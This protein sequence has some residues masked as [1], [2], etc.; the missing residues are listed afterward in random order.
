MTLISESPKNQSYSRQDWQKGYESQPNEDDYVIE[1]IE[2]KIPEELNGTLFR[3]GPGLLDI[4]GQKYHH[5]F[6]GDGMISAIT[7]KN[8]KAHFRNRFVETEGYLAEKNAG[9]I[10][11]RG[12]FGTQKPGGLLANIFD[13]KM[14][15]IANTNVIYLGEKLLALWEA[16]QPYHLNPHTLNTIGLDNLEGI[17]KPGEAFSAHPRVEKGKNGGR[18]RVIN[19]SVKPGISS[20]IT[21]YELESNGKLLTKYSHKIPGFSFLHDMAITPNYC[22]FFQNP[23]SFNPLPYLFG[24][25]GAAECINFNP[26][27][28]TQIILIP[29]DGSNDVKIIDTEP[30][31][32]FHHANAWEEDDRVY[33]DSIC[34]KQFN[35]IEGNKDF[36]EVNFDVMPEGQ[37]WRFQINLSNQEV[38]HQ[39]IAQRSCEFPTLNPNNVGQNYR[40]LYIGAAHNPTGNAPLQGILKIDFLTGNRQLWSAAPRGFSGEPTFVPRPNSSAEDDGWLLIVIYNAEYHRSELVI[41][42]A[43][44]FTKKPVAKL[45]LKNHIPYGLHGCFIP[46]FFSTIP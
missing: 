20:T 45:H 30:C 46:D 25:S 33:I 3:N 38:K 10:L 35:K 24:F 36:R 1:D 19:F 39:V 13:T 15:N 9:K 23:V 21:I 41:L 8:G 2:G 18:D 5:P 28:P 32:I 11:Y 43:Q 26:K 37:L 42:D 22:I 17:L 14:K 29:R 7:L 44:D 4:N 16:A 6:D 12:V 34:Y 27:Q 31:F 40:Y